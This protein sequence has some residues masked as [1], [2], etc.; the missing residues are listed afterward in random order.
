MMVA[1][2]ALAERD[3]KHAAFHLAAA[4]S[5][6]PNDPDA[7]R[8]LDVAIDF[9][10]DDPLKIAPVGKDNWAAL[11]AVRARVLQKLGQTEEAVNLLTQVTGVVKNV[12]Y[13][14]CAL[15]WLDEIELPGP[16]RP[17]TAAAFVSGFVS[18]F[19]GMVVTDP[20]AV[21][22]FTDIRP[23][24]DRLAAA[25]QTDES[26]RA[27][28]AILVRKIGDPVDAIAV[29]ESAMNDAPGYT[30]AVAA[31]MAYA[32]ADR[33]ADAIAMYH[34][35]MAFNDRGDA[36][37]A[38][39]A[40]LY[41]RTGDYA[42]C[43]RWNDE[44]LAISPTHATAL[45]MKIFLAAVANHDFRGL[46]Y[47]EKFV[48]DKPKSTTTRELLNR[49]RPFESFLPPPDDAVINGMR[50]LQ[51]KNPGQILTATKWTLGAVV[52]PSALLS[53]ALA[54]KST[55]A[56]MILTVESIAT[57]DP[58][59]PRKP[60]K[61]LLW[62]YEGGKPVPAVPVPPAYVSDEI[63]KA[64]HRLFDADAGGISPAAWRSISVRRRSLRC[65][66][67]WSIPPPC[68][69]ASPPGP[70]STTCRR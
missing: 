44:V 1:R 23:T 41:M 66:A 46:T 25:F 14:K 64:A 13:G 60:V 67:C 3:P 2:D 59:K 24:I 35:A 58:R 63:A 10:G 29:A 47:L 18:R 31:A 65:S 28:H 34:K 32:R 39:L 52:A 48:A 70:G 37:R 40:V 69:T 30:T 11:M 12:P 50:N 42:N 17:K 33:L 68:P 20:D 61:Y 51:A 16:I 55:L 9:A 26:V 49:L 7:L 4:L 57:P 56:E 53:V 6:E 38:D 21:K 36:V 5:A 15:G 54:G 62:K 22:T 45:P 27:M 8:L 43:R 19:P